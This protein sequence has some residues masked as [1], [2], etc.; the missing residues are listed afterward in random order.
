MEFQSVFVRVLL[1]L[2][3][4][5]FLLVAGRNNFENKKTFK[6]KEVANNCTF[7]NIQLTLDDYEWEP[8]AENPELIDNVHF[9]NCTIPVLT[10]NICQY[11][12]SLREINVNRAHLV[13][14][15]EDAFYDCAVLTRV[16]LENNQIEHIPRTTFAQGNIHRINLNGNRI[17]KL[18]CWLFNLANLTE[19]SVS[20][21]NLTEFDPEIIKFNRNL[22]ILKLSSNDLADID[23]ET[24]V[25]NH[26]KLRSFQFDDNEISCVRAVE[27]IKMLQNRKIKTGDISK[28]KD[29]YYT[30]KGVFEGFK[31]NG[32]IE[33]MASNN[34]KDDSVV[35]NTMIELIEKE[36]IIEERLL[37]AE[38][39]L[40][41]LQSSLMAELKKQTAILESA[42][43]N[44]TIS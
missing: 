17:Q 38:M 16:H 19:I 1:F 30:Q 40:K 26:P 41:Q 28:F 36:K 10:K 23:I 5:N 2:S 3:L 44:K 15:K 34:R 37:M 20:A 39:K 12:V 22:K 11:F 33:W 31:C 29:R 18:D 27:M 42:C 32:D 8:E 14:V 35:K 4:I 43:S 21:N 25:E 9:V 7:E 24:V 13:E 6:C